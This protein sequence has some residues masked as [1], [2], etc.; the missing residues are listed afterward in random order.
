MG[1]NGIET[2]A[3]IGLLATLI[4]T[5]AYSARKFEPVHAVGIEQPS[6]PLEPIPLTGLETEPTPPPKESIPVEVRLLMRNDYLQAWRNALPA[7]RDVKI[8]DFGPKGHKGVVKPE[9]GLRV[10]KGPNTSFKPAKWVKWLDHDET[11]NFRYVIFTFDKE[12]GDEESWIVVDERTRP[13]SRWTCESGWHRGYGICFSAAWINGEEFI[14]RS[15]YPPPPDE[16]IRTFSW[17]RSK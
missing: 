12:T 2:L 5:A 16:V 10:R 13:G 1:R 3:R 8:V 17:P 15:A 11:V 7:S 6:A 4:A 14:D 9:E